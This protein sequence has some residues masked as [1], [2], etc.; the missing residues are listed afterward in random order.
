MQG[1]LADSRALVEA[2]A[3]GRIEPVIDSVMPLSDNAAA[4][5]RL[6]E[7]KQFGKVVLVPDS[8][9]ASHGANQIESR[10][11]GEGE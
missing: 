2:I 10:L 8:V 3:A 9:L 1:A 6:E 7:R 11:S 4:E 5:Q